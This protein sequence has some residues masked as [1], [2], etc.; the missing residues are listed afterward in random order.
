MLRSGTG[1]ELRHDIPPLPPPVSFPGFDPSILLDHHILDPNDR[2]VAVWLLLHNITPP[3]CFSLFC[4]SSPESFSECRKRSFFSFSSTQ[5]SEMLNI[6]EL[7]SMKFQKQF[8]F[9]RV[10]DEIEK[11][12]KAWKRAQKT[13]KKNQ[14]L[15][16]NFSLGICLESVAAW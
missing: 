8:R 9:N 13:R 4:F 3:F 5:L 12:A 15:I 14:K 7:I 6:I 11:K 10:K 2:W 16:K 1:L